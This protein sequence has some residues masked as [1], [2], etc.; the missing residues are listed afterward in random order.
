MGL[1]TSSCARHRPRAISEVFV[2]LGLWHNF[3]HNRP[4]QTQRQICR[5][6]SGHAPSEVF[7]I[8][9]FARPAMGPWLL[10][11]ANAASYPRRE[12]LNSFQCPS[13][14]TSTYPSVGLM[15][16]SPSIAYAFTGI[17]APDFSALAMELS[18]MPG[19]VSSSTPKDFQPNWA[20]GARSSR[21]L[22]TRHARTAPPRRA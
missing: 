4:Y 12:A 14:M 19:A 8:T 7:A 13:E 6:T 3:G 22:I 21:P 11:N 1:D 10:R 2:A 20:I 5:A 9:V 15:A 18:G 16:V 17:V